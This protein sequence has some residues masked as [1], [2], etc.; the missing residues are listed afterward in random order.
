M[1]RDLL[2]IGL[3]GKSLTDL[4]RRILRERPPFAIVLFGRNIGDA[5]Q[6]RDLI[7]EVK[8]V[9]TLP[10]L[11]MIDEEGGRVDRLRH[12]IPGLPSAEGFAEGAK[13]RELAEWQG[14]VIGMAL[15][16]FDIEVD[17]APVVDIRGEHAPKGLERRIFGTDAETVVDL[18]GAFMRG[19]HATGTASVPKHFPGIGLGSADSHYGTT[20]IDLSL[21]EMMRRDLVPYQ[22]LGAEAGAVIVGHG[23][24]PRIDGSESPAT[25]SS[26]IAHDLLRDVLHFEGLAISDDME[27]HAVSDLGPYESIAERALM[28]GNDCV[29]FCSHIER[30]PDLQSHIERRVK[31]D[32][33]VRA[34]FDEAFARCERYRSHCERLRKAAAPPPS[35]AAVLDETARFVEEYKRT[36]PHREVIVPDLERRTNDRKPRTGREEWT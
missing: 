8:S 21:D 5:T 25:L 9:A 7:A 24:Y 23:S 22:R 31:D 27:M 28:A 10:P 26:K 19:L 16:W 4:E 13:P 33:A 1:Q 35:F 32:A 2:G 34:R 18:A 36:R 6:L 15:R 11:M 14:R 30:V 17:L 12:L 3:A 29:L 20:I